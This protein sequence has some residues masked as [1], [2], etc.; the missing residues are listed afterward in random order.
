MRNL[1]HCHRRNSLRTFT[2]TR[3][4]E[5]PQK[6]SPKH[7]FAWLG[8]PGE[9]AARAASV[10]RLVRSCD[11]GAGELCADSGSV[12][13]GPGPGDACRLL[14]GQELLFNSDT[15]HIALLVLPIERAFVMQQGARCWWQRV[16]V[17][18][19]VT[20]VS[21][22]VAEEATTVGAASGSLCG[23][24]NSIFDFRERV[25]EREKNS[26]SIES[27]SFC[28]LVMFAVSSS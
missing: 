23:K 6:L 27:R 21:E 2:F 19:F 10:G 22:E 4:F 24:R 16:R 20:Q 12:D 7:A 14:G 13:H 5:S 17:S 8:S 1:Q 28:H 15:C 26:L 18:N 9:Q 3:P 25:A 11:R